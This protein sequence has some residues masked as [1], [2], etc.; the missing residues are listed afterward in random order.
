MRDNPI[1][2][3]SVWFRLV[4]LIPAAARPYYC[5][6]TH[7]P[8]VKY[9]SPESNPESTLVPLSVPALRSQVVPTET[10]ELGRFAGL[11]FGFTENLHPIQTLVP[12][13]VIDLELG[14]YQLASA[15][16]EPSGAIEK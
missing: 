11:S 3:L 10:S 16:S 15:T 13:L 4:D 8:R 6:H 12:S 7:T 1:P 9:E 5:V 14:E 2:T